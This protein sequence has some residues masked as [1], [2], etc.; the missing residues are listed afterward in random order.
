MGQRKG[1]KNWHTTLKTE[2]AQ[3]PG[4]QVGR[5]I[6]STARQICSLSGHD[7]QK[8]S[9]KKKPGNKPIN[10]EARRKEVQTKGKTGKGPRD[11][12]GSLKGFTN[13]IRRKIKGEP[14]QR[15]I[16]GQ[17]GVRRARSTKLE[18]NRTSDTP[19]KGREGDEIKKRERGD[20]KRIV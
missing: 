15:G 3:G 6:S 8:G 14:R 11:D 10:P 4:G 17:K 7:E 1:E 19:R 18:E 2:R 12:F 16:W 9:V 5:G 13:T 20:Q